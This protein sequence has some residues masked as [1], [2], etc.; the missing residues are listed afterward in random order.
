MF[1]GHDRGGWASTIIGDYEPY[2]GF[3]FWVATHSSTRKVKDIEAHPE[4]DIYY[5]L[6]E[7]QG[8][9]CVIGNGILKM[10]EISKRWL[11]RDKWKEYW[12]QRP[13]FSDYIPIKIE[14]IR[15]EYYNQKD[16]EFLSDGYATIIIHL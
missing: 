2:D 3:N 6:I 11:W 15:I 12:P 8:Y 10:D 9:M 1:A 7:E 16:N 4:I 14:P 13:L 5:P